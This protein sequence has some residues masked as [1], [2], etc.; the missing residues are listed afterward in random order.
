MPEEKE[1]K[2]E[3]AKPVKK[4][5]TEKKITVKHGAWRG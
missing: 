5:V 4:V 1:V 2:K 3:V